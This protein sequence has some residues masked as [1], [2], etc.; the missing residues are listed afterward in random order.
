MPHE[1]VAL[2]LARRLKGDVYH[3]QHAGCAKRAALVKATQHE[4]R[5][6]R[7]HRE[8]ERTEQREASGDLSKIIARRLAGA[9]TR[10]EAAVLLQILRHFD[11]IERHARIE[12]TEA[13][14]QKRI[15]DVVNRAAGAHVR[16]IERIERAVRPELGKHARELEEREREDQRQNA[17]GVRLDR[18]IGALPTIHLAADNALCILHGDAALCLIHM[19]DQRDKADNQNGK[20]QQ[21]PNGKRANKELFA[22]VDERLGYA[23][24]DGCKDQH[25][26]AVANAILGDALAEP[27]QECGTSG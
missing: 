4:L 13:D 24:N 25:R 17:V 10:D 2:E 11:R 21:F 3:N 5:Q 7:D 14:D 6:D 20:H 23:R 1:H 18:Q 12:E 15:D 16:F 26:N 27:H 19:R 22:E 8:E 9:D